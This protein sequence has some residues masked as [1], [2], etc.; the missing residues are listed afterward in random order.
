MDF[1][2]TMKTLMDVH[3]LSQHQQVWI[4]HVTFIPRYLSLFRYVSPKC[5]TYSWQLRSG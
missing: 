5:V 3:F 2:L 1:D 4:S